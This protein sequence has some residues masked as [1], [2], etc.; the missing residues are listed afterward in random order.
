MIDDVYYNI[1]TQ[2]SK[3]EESL[4]E[5]DQNCS[6]SDFGS[7]NQEEQKKYLESLNIE[8]LWIRYAND[9]LS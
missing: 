5:E 6:F 4:Y 7:D 3:I 8:K 9:Q 2:L 1:R